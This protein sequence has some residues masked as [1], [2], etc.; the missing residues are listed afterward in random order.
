MS[1]VNENLEDWADLYAEEIIA[2]NPKIGV[3][4]PLSI[5]SKSIQR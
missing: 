5:R 3:K 2:D 4:I 1:I